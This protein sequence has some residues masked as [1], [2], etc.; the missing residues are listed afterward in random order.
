M[1]TAIYYRV[2]TNK[3]DIGMQ[4]K[5]IKDYCERDQIEIYKEYSDVGVSGSKT[6]RPQFDLMLQDM[7]ARK[8][9]CIV[10][11]ELSRIGRSLQHLLKLFE[12]FKAKRINFI[13][14]TQNINTTTAE[15]RMFLHML[16]VL[17]EYE[18]ELTINRINDGLKRAKADGKKL[19]RPHGSKDKKRRRKSGY[20]NRWLSKQ[21][22]PSK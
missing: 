22:P 1:K 21:S 10:V 7:R 3:Q 13:S 17:A 9:N 19:G 2:S 20:I 15:G 14:L 5:A 8:F 12:E 18:R 4:K 11:Y 6:S 16:M